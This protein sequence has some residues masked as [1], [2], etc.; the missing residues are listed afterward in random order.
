MF[1]IPIFPPVGTSMNLYMCR[2]VCELRLCHTH[3]GMYVTGYEDVIFCRSLCTY[4]RTYARHSLITTD[5][6]NS[7]SNSN[8]THAHNDAAILQQPTSNIDSCPNGRR[9]EGDHPNRIIIIISMV[10]SYL[11]RTTDS[12]LGGRCDGR[13]GRSVCCSSHHM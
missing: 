5:N 7:N 2:N 4:V 9:N 11:V 8:H 3:T 6:R 13:H 12:V 10:L 1:D